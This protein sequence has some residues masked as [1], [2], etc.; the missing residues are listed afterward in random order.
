[1]ASWIIIIALLSFTASYTFKILMIIKRN[2]AV[3]EEWYCITLCIQ[4]EV[5]H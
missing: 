3:D 1:M 2:I 5:T 4:Q